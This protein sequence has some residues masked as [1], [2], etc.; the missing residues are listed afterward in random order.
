MALQE[1][2]SYF[3]SKRTD[4]KTAAIIIIILEICLNITLMYTVENSGQ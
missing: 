4:M 2:N 3:N 1:W